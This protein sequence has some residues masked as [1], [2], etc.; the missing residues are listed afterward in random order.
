MAPFERAMMVSYRL[1][2]VTVALCETTRQQFAIECLQRSNEQGMGD[3]GPKFR[4]WL[5]EQCFTPP[6]TQYRLYGR[7]F[8]QVKRPNQQYQ[9]TEGESCKGKQHKKNT[10]KTEIT[11]MHA[12]TK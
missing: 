9:T 10:K 8:L 2:I 11:H 7:R 3:F 12:H 5:I 6:P 4:G 1:S